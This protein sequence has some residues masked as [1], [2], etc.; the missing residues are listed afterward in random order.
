MS[1]CICAIY[2]LSLAEHIIHYF[3]VWTAQVLFKQTSSTDLLDI[4]FI[5]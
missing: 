1:A 5:S 4:V 2:L 3:S